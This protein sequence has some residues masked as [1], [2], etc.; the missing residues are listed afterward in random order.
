MLPAAHGHPGARTTNLCVSISLALRSQ[1]AKG[2]VSH[3]SL[4]FVFLS[5]PTWS[6]ISTV[7]THSSTYLTVCVC[8]CVCVCMCV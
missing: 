7:E 8:V 6:P 2:H 5:R 3:P 1:E 4:S